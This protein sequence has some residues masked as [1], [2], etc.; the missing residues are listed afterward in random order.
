MAIDYRLTDYRRRR[1]YHPGSCIDRAAAR[2]AGTPT[3]SRARRVLL[4]TPGGKSAVEC[5][6]GPSR[7]H[8]SRKHFG[9]AGNSFS[10]KISE[11]FEFLI[12][13]C[14]D[15]PAVAA[16]FVMPVI[17]IVASIGAALIALNP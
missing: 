14:R 4:A 8:I 1:D 7:T 13:E 12:V 6:S 11:V 16:F 3:P 17:V 15:D 10:R 5:V 2:I 9:T